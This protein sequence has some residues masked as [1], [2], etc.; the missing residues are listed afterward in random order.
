M[1]RVFTVVSLAMCTA[2]PALGAGVFVGHVALFDSYGTTGGGEFRA[3]TTDLS[4][5]PVNSGTSFQGGIA[6]TA[7]LFETF[8][9]EYNEEINFNTPYRA[10]LNDRTLASDSAYNGG[11]HGGN[12]DQLDS[13]TAYLYTAFMNH[14]LA[15]GYDYSNAFTRSADADALQTAIWHIEQEDDGSGLSGLAL[16]YW[17]EAYNAVNVAHTWS[18]IGNVRIL[19]LV[20]D[21]GGNHQDQLVMIPLPGVAGMGAMGLAAVGVRRRRRA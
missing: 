12:A 4:F 15:S 11:A 13:M 20:D 5:T 2:G 19:N 3:S 17:T 9:V 21:A 10:Y 16:A 18:G 14:T 1:N 8:C 6:S 7:G